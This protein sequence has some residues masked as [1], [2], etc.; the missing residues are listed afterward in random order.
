MGL[1]EGK[2]PAMAIDPEERL[3]LLLRDLRTSKDGLSEREAQRRLTQFGANLLERRRRRRWLPELGRQFTHPLA[4]L[5]WAAAALAWIAGI[6]A[7]AVAIVVVIAINAAFAF[8]QEMQAERAVEA[9]AQY[10]PERARALRDGAPVEVPT[11]EL[12]PGDVV[13]LGEGERISADARLL[14][15]AL[16]I[17][18]STLT[19]E[20]M[21]VFRSASYADA[22]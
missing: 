5:L 8:A 18:L 6:L 2:T 19:G 20:S 7:V 14:E 13:L 16:E 12:V 4:L 22:G 1:D 11:T 15:G 9:L 3:E 17:D 10:L 21:P